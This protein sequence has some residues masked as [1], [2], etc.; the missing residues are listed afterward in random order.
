MVWCVKYRHPVLTN[1]I[2]ED[3]INILNKI[4][5][6][7]KFQILECNSDK[8]HIHLLINC[9]PQHYI[10]DMIKALKCVSTRLLMKKHGE[11]LKKKL[12]GEH[13]WNPSYFV[14]T[15]SENTEEQIRKYINNQKSK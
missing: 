9:S 5:K 8:D 3:L 10:P 11:Q 1:E 13:L 6:D 7:N 12:W 4:A 2:E 15:V 14:A